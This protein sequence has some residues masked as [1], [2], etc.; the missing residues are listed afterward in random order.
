MSACLYTPEKSQAICDKIS[1]G[2]SQRKA[3]ESE[4]IEEQTFR[5][6]KREF[7][8]ALAQYRAARE[9]RNLGWSEELIDIVDSVDMQGD[10]ITVRNRIALAK[11]R[12]NARQWSISRI[13]KDFRDKQENIHSGTVDLGAAS[14]AELEAKLRKFGVL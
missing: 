3:C 7:P 6:W 2:M 4:G 10:P 12:M 14:D 13:L 11:E 5:A 8:E 9:E 1:E